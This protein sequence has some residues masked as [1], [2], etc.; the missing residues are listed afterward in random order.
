MLQSS[1]NGH[2]GPHRLTRVA[3]I[4]RPERI[5]PQP[6]T[7]ARKAP[8]G[9]PSR[10]TFEGWRSGMTMNGSTFDR[11]GEAKTLGAENFPR[12]APSLTRLERFIPVRQVVEESAVAVIEIQRMSL[13][14]WI[15]RGA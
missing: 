6:S 2:L 14:E 8:V 9:G 3:I 1:S 12:F 13:Q 4:P 15:N 5:A 10:Y 7:E 11:P